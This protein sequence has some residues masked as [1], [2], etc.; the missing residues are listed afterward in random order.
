MY[1]I[2][3]FKPINIEIL[4]LRLDG[5]YRNCVCRSYIEAL[6]P[7]RVKGVKK[8][9]DAITHA[10]MHKA[11]YYLPTN[12]SKTTCRGALTS[13]N[14]NEWYNQCVCGCNKALKINLHF[15]QCATSKDNQSGHNSWVDG[16]GRPFY[17][18]TNNRDLLGSRPAHHN[19]SGNDERKKKYVGANPCCHSFRERLNKGCEL[20]PVQRPSIILVIRLLQT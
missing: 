12:I 16:V 14:I 3:S 18:G 4:I 15:T 6:G 1:N 11:T 2:Q 10:W 13:Q 20:S 5:G 7:L 8:R 9:V 19:D 17:N